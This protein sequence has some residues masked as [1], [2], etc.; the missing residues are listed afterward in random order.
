MYSNSPLII[1][2]KKV[3]QNHTTN[4]QISHLISIIQTHSISPDYIFQISQN[5]SAAK[6]SEGELME[7]TYINRQHTKLSK[8]H[9]HFSF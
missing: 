3:S 1:N 4:Q 5:N 2:L 9:F 8:K 6:P 7:K